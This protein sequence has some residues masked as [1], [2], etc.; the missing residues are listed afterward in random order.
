[1]QL[2]VSSAVGDPGGFI[3]KVGHTGQEVVSQHLSSREN[4]ALYLRSSSWFPFQCDHQL[5]PI[6]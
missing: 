4:W 6:R 1:M 5:C 3:S 2:G